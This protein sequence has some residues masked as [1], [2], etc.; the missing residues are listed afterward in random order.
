MKDLASLTLP[1]FVKLYLLIFID[2]LC[3][4]LEHL[5]SLSFMIHLWLL[6]ILYH[7]FSCELKLKD[8]YFQVFH[9][10]MHSSNQVLR[11]TT[12]QLI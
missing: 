1:T 6:A 4:S 2:H 10:T 12:L 5:I 9:L 3:F 7:A 8:P 11:S